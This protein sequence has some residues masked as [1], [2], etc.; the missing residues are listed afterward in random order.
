[1]ESRSKILGHPLHPILI[2]F[3][4]GLLT[5]SVIFD[6]VAF[7]TASRYYSGIAYWMLAAGLIGGA[8]AGAAG[9][10]DYRAIPARTR[11]KR[12]AT[13]HAVGN[14]VVLFLFGF[15]WFLRFPYP[16]QPKTGAE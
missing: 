14:V 3:P 5:T 11:A 16:E 10:I 8:V 4:L 15:S 13:Y 2:V 12:I 7:W 1:M 6:M 9:F